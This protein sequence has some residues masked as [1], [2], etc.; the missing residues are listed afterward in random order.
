MINVLGRNTCCH[1]SVKLLNSRTLVGHCR[2]VWLV[3]SFVIFSTVKV[4]SCV[5]QGKQME[6]TSITPLLIPTAC[7]ILKI[8]LRALSAGLNSTLCLV[9]MNE[10]IKYFLSSSENWTY[11]RRVYMCPCASLLK[12]KISLVSLE[13]YILKLL[14]YF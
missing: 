2:G 3:T 6:P 14:F 5:Q 12:F 10:N 13:D 7:W 11:S 9:N 4:L 8:L 1:F